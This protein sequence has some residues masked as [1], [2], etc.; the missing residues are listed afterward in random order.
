MPQELDLW[1]AERALGEVEQEAAL[2][3]PLE[4]LS[5]VTDVC[6]FIQA[7]HQNII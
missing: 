4:D 7:C 5:H 6:G 3:H 1:L 2:S